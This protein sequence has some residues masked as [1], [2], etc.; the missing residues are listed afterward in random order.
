LLNRRTDQLSG[1]EKQRIA[2]TRLLIGSPRLLL[3]DEPFSNL[4]AVHKGIMKSV[5]DD[6]TLKPVITCIMV[7]HDAPDTLPW[8]DTIL[9]M[10][11]GEIIQ[12]GKP[13]QV[14]RQPIDEY[15]AAL[16]GDYNL[17]NA[18]DAAVLH[19]KKGAS[20]QKKLLVRP[21]Q[22]I[23]STNGAGLAATI[24]SISFMGSYYT[25]EAFTGRQLLKI[26]CISHRLTKGENVQLSLADASV[27]YM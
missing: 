13:E 21:E 4:D 18:V 9:V 15:C 22:L 8:A 19:P 3:L 12:Q 14:Y 24:Q 11:D 10:K 1:G 7:S 6:I 2:L 17:V 25:I 16:F 5:I 23:I 20:N 27:Q 26:K